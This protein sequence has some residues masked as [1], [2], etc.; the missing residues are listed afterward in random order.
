MKKRRRSPN[1]PQDEGARPDY[2]G[3]SQN[4]GTRT[5]FMGARPHYFGCSP[6]TNKHP[7]TFQSSPPLLPSTSADPPST[8]LPGSGGDHT[9]LP[10]AKAEETHLGHDGLGVRPLASVWTVGDY[11][12][13][14]TEVRI[15]QDFT[16]V[17]ESS[18]LRRELH[19]KVQQTHSPP[20]TW[21]MMASVCGLWPQYGQL[22]TTQAITL[23]SGSSR[24]SLQF[25]NLPG[26]GRNCI[27]SSVIS[28]WGW[29]QGVLPAC[30]VAYKSRPRRTS[31]QSTASDGHCHTPRGHNLNYTI[32]TLYAE[33][34]S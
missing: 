28:A 2:F 5:H 27:R 26:L 29:G 25:L 21:G 18:W 15:R 22:E 34:V 13:H 20:H 33:S 19:R 30:W 1:L 17:P 16:S 7:S 3:C 32:W 24:T 9:P 14:H 8:P 31:G 10:Q 4:G 6:R 23:K 12:G 11:P